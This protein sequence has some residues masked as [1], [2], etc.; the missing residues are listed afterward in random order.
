MDFFIIYEMQVEKHQLEF[1]KQNSNLQ[2][3]LHISW[4]SYHAE[5]SISEPVFVLEKM[6]SIGMLQRE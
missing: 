6:Y 3:D 4:L 1:H 5:N 2:N